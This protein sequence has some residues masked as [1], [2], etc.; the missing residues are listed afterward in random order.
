MKFTLEMEETHYELGREDSRYR[1]FKKMLM[2]KTYE[3]LRELF[4]E[5][6]E[7]GLIEK[8]SYPEDVKNGW[9]ETESGGSG[10]LNSKEF[11]AFLEESR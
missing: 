2:E 8:T 9:K 4:E 6:S 10:F 7:I 1:F 5:L 3:S 11:D